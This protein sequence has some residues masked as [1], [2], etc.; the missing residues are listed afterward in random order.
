MASHF[1]SLQ[2]SIFLCKRS[3]K[4]VC[5]NWTKVNVCSR[6][7]SKPQQNGL[8]PKGLKFQVKPPIGLTQPNMLAIH[9]SAQHVNNT[10]LMF[11]VTALFAT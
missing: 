11:L 10:R 1:L 4:G 6:S 9:G 7:T 5:L 3:L 2:L 8:R